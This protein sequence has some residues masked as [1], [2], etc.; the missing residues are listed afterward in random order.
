MV[1][2][3]ELFAGEEGKFGA[4]ARKISWGDGI[5]PIREGLSGGEGKTR[6]TAC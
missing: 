6:P 2:L 5:R 1:E 4:S 3:V